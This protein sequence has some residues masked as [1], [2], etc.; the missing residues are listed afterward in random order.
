MDATRVGDL[1][2][3][4]LNPWIFLA[5]PALTFVLATADAWLLAMPR[6][7]PL[8]GEWTATF[9][10]TVPLSAAACAL[11]TW[12][13]LRLRRELVRRGSTEA[14]LRV[15]LEERD[16]AIG[17]LSSG[18][19]RERRLRRELDH[20]VRNNLSSLLGL[21]GLYEG[22]DIGASELVRSMRARIAALREVYGL[23]SSSPEEGVDLQELLERIVGSMM[24]PDDVRR[25]HCSGAHV[26][27][28]GRESN[29]LAMIV[30]ELVT[31]A[32]K[33]GAL[34]TQGGSIRVTWST[35]PVA[36]GTDLALSWQETTPEIVRTATHGA[37]GM[38]LALI[39]GIARSDLR[40]GVQFEIDRCRWT[41]R[42][43]AHLIG[44]SSPT[45]ELKEQE[46]YS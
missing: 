28:S 2:S 27:L 26:R 31:N 25:F 41:I 45:T 43:D 37:H 46:I 16:A 9:F 22:T 17:D 11:T 33:H 8:S 36:S 1:G 39:E 20:R 12:I 5:V 6:S 30:Q 10:T 7:R 21:V 34:R 14:R 3:K 23:I 18:L 4:P 35:R 24:L 19:E 38:G 42:I 13:L 44:S 40:G 32:A 15:A 29:A